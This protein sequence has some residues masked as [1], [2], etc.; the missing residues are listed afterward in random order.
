MK[1]NIPEYNFWPLLFFVLVLLSISFINS[2]GTIDVL[3]WI[4]WI[5]DFRNQGIITGY[6]HSH[7]DYPPL[8]T[9]IFYSFA[10]FFQQFGA[11]DFISVKITILIFAFLSSGLIFFH[12]RSFQIT[13]LFHAG[14]ILNSVCLGYSDVIIT[15]FLILA[16]ISLQKNNLLLFSIVFATSIFI[17]WQTLIIAP[18]C[19]IYI[20]H[21]EKFNWSFIQR[22]SIQCALPVFF[23]AALI[24]FT[25]GPDRMFSTFSW[26][27]NHRW[28]SANALN[29]HWILTYIYRVFFPETFGGLSNGEIL[30]IGTENSPAI[31][32]I[33]KILFLLMY[34]YT[35]FIFYKAKGSFELLLGFMLSS[36]LLYFTFN[37]GVHENHLFMAMIFSI[38]L[39]AIDKKYLSLA[40]YI[41]IA[42]NINMLLFYGLTGRLGVNRILFE[43]FDPTL[44][45]AICN[46]LF[47]SYIWYQWIA[48]SKIDTPE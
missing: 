39:L 2:P 36:Y 10:K 33:T 34:V 11:S 18:V 40:A 22:L 28:L 17:K 6:A 41:V 12:T 31:F 25:F 32:V 43:T 42:F 20:L 3:S 16:F 24:I 44:P 45:Y 4:E 29:F 15:F 23:I 26:A 9:L 38:L 5:Q 14:F 7:T 27:L 35:L 8:T 47:F 1:Q 30:Y 13:S 19:F 48:K 21:Q 46:S 37:T